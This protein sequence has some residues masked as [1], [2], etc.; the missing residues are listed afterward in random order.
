MSEI[1]DKLGM[2]DG[3]GAGKKKDAQPVPEIGDEKTL[4]R[5]IDEALRAT[6]RPEFLNRIDDTV[7]FHPLDREQVAAILD[8]QLDE[9]KLRMSEQ[10]FTLTVS[11]AAKELLLEKGWDP[12]FG[13]RPLRRAIQKELEDPISMLILEQNC[14]EGTAF[15]ADAAEGKISLETVTAAELAL[16]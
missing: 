12:K 8:L 15:E 3:H 5:A 10:G 9:L 11:S 13:G 16:P 1:S 6:F 4:S 7:V 2:D 14:P